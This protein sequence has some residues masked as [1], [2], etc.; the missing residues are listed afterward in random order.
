MVSKQRVGVGV[1]SGPTRSHRPSRHPE[2]LYGRRAYAL[3]QSPANPALHASAR[4]IQSLISSLF[5]DFASRA[6][7]ASHAMR[8]LPASCLST[9]RLMACQNSLPAAVR[10]FDALPDDQP[11]GVTVIPGT[12]H[13]G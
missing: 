5:R 10:I 6:W 9:L 13:A 7:A 4:S 12:L 3:L 1:C 11:V 2:R 8:R